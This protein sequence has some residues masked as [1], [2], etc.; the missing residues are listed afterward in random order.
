MHML[1]VFI[2][3]V[4]NYV[5]LRVSKGSHFLED[6]LEHARFKSCQSVVINGDDGAVAVAV[7]CAASQYV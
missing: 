6:R 3:Q 1:I 2:T 5:G 4:D 7:T